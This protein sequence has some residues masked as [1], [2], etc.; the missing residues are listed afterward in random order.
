ML[1][2]QSNFYRVI[3]FLSFFLFFAYFSH[4]NAELACCLFNLSSFVF[5]IVFPVAYIHIQFARYPVRAVRVWWPGQ[6]FIVW[7]T[8]KWQYPETWAKPLIHGRTR[9]ITRT[10]EIAVEPKFAAFL[11]SVQQHDFMCSFV[12]DPGL[13]K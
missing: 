1:F 9:R 3:N 11:L 4:D 6:K 12:C 5:L 10:N 13:T 2:F 8:I 7:S